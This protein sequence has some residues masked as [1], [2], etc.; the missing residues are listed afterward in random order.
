MFKRFLSVI[1]VIVL[2]SGCGGQQPQ[3][4][5]STPSITPLPSATHTPVP[6]STNTPTPT[7]TPTPTP[8]PLA[9]P[10]TD[11]AMARLGKGWVNDL[12]FS[13]NGKIL[14][15]ATS[16]GVYLYQVETMELIA[17]IPG[18]SFVKD[19][20]FIDDET[21]VVG[22]GDGTTIVWDIKETPKILETLQR[23]DL[24]VALGVTEEKSILIV[25]LGRSGASGSVNI[26]IWDRT[27]PESTKKVSS[28]YVF[29][30]QY[31]PTKNLLAL[32]T[33]MLSKVI[34]VDTQRMRTKAVM[35]TSCSSFALSKNG[36][37]FAANQFHPTADSE[38]LIMDTASQKELFSIKDGS[39][40][41]AFSP[42]EKLLVSSSAAGL[43][44]W[45]TESF[46][47]MNTIDGESAQAG[48][49]SPDGSLLA[50]ISRDGNLAIRET[51]DGKTMFAIQG[52]ASLGN[53]TFQD[54]FMASTYESQSMSVLSIASGSS[55]FY[56]L[57]GSDIYFRDI[58]T[59]EIIRSIELSDEEKD[60]LGRLTSITFSPDE[61]IL[62]STWDNWETH[63]RAILLL[64]PK[65]GDRLKTLSGFGP[66]AF[67][68]NASLLATG[69]AENR[70]VIWDIESGE[71]LPVSLGLVPA[72]FDEPYKESLL[73][74]PDNSMIVILSDQVIFR[75]IATGEQVKVLE[76]G[77]DQNL[78]FYDRGGSGALGAFSPDGMILASTWLTATNDDKIKDT[79]GILILWDVLT[80]EKIT[81][82]D[83]H[84]NPA[85]TELADSNPITALAFSSDGRYLVSGTED[86]FIIVWDVQN[87]SL[88]EVLEGHTGAINSVAF[89]PDGKLLYSNAMDGTVVIWDMEQLLP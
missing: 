4:I 43:S 35:C 39:R 26:V 53:I 65:T 28:E 12:E 66:V 59:G 29:E 63:N 71:Q 41:L 52:F 81:I 19:A 87:R 84:S 15:V 20:V 44:F 22:S 14:S 64:D 45:N 49:F 21:L 10:V 79:K 2:L 61:T 74:S 85:S 73:F 69:G 67:S 83:G 42:D 23:P 58:S 13:P 72:S 76:S 16:I 11:S 89:S 70:L 8:L 25:E 38:M 54:T 75:D 57:S 40:P 3:E 31:S 86:G 17:F 46:E 47:L 6:T 60:E 56:S 82:L 62:A 51:S 24:V 55:G 88:L 5:I 33:I 9:G 78:R 36:E 48:A 1:L 50:T 32:S 27:N 37:L 80:G 68:S 34:L 77:L 7:L 30:G 18:N